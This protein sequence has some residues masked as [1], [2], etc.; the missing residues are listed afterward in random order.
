VDEAHAAAS[1]PQ[2]PLLDVVFLH[3]IRGGPFV[4]WRHSGS[5]ESAAEQVRSEASCG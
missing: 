4:T 2:P 5:A 1:A 3:G